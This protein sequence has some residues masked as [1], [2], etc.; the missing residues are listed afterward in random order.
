MNYDTTKV[1]PGDVFQIM[2]E[3]GRAG[4]IGCFVLCTEV[5]AW[6]I[7]GFVGWPDEHTKQSQAYIRLPWDQIEFIGKALLMPQSEDTE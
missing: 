3:E 1:E 4:W 7:Q 5:K 2:P 6:G